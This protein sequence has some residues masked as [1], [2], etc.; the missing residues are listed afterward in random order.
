[1]KGCHLFK[2][3]SLITMVLNERSILS[4]ISC[5][6][7]D[8]IPSNNVILYVALTL[9]LNTNCRCTDNNKPALVSEL[10]SLAYYY[11]MSKTLILCHAN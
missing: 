7:C 3:I 5:L 11:C 10:P 9:L 4:D 6:V 2:V 1:M 8:T